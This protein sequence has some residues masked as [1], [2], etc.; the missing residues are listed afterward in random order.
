MP[1][2]KLSDATNYTTVTLTVK[3]YKCKSDG[4][5][6][7]EKEISNLELRKLGSHMSGSL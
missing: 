5:S 1:E 2:N 7:G 3:F 6:L 4:E